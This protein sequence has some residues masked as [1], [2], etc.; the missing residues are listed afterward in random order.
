MFQSILSCENIAFNLLYNI[1]IITDVFWYLAV[2]QE[3]TMRKN[4]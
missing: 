4:V 1:E 3:K 2:Y